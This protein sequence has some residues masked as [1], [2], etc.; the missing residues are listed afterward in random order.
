MKADFPFQLFD[1]CR[2][3]KHN[4]FSRQ[5]LRCRMKIKNISVTAQDIQYLHESNII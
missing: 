4:L 2:V 5:V 1:I 3:N